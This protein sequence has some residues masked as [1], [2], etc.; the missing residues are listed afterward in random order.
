MMRSIAVL[1]TVTLL[2]IAATADDSQRIEYGKKEE[3]RGVKTIFID[4][5]SNLEFRENAIDT[6]R[7]ELPSVSVADKERDADIMLQVKIVGSDAK[8]GH[9][10]M[11]VLGR[12]SEA[13][14]VRIIAKYEDEKSSIW[15][16]KLSTV[17]I[18]RFIR[19]WQ[20]A[21]RPK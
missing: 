13:G 3:L 17:L 7:K 15:T 14:A 12:A 16:R 1:I 8:H 6:L 5:G 2:T 18:R 4:S 19:D 21:N 9:A 20:D 11:L 10:L